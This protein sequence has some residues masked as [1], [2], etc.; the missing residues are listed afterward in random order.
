M[1]DWVVFP[2]LI[3][4]LAGY[5]WANLAAFGVIGVPW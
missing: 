2:V 1:S 3:L 5:I 4:A